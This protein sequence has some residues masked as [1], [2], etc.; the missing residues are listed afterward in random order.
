MRLNAFYKDFRGGFNTVSL[1]QPITVPVYRFHDDDQQQKIVYE[2]TGEMKTYND[3][4][5]NIID[6]R[7]NSYTY[8]FDWSLSI[9]R[10]PGIN[11]SVSTSTSYIISKENI[12]GVYD[13][14]YLK[15][16]V[17]Y[18]GQN[19]WYAIYDPL[20]KD[21]RHILTSKLNTTTHIP[22]IGF[23]VMTNTDVFWAN[24][25]RS[26][27]KDNLQSAI[28]YLDKDL[29]FIRVGPEDDIVLPP[30]AVSLITSNQPIVYANF[31]MSVAKEIGRKIRIA[32]TTYNTFNIM[33][34]YSTEFNGVERVTV[35]N[36]PLSITGGITIKL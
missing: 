5:Y 3:I 7:K 32:I 25:S 31:S 27:Y 20:S 19:I 4:S 16:P 1:Y 14:V 29:N 34:I 35:F 21:Q 28:G 9:D 26:Q 33:P 12:A 10:I 24:K 36:S 8:G 22:K 11:T 15:S 30:R 17:D 18:K 2:Q 6:N 23:V 13:R